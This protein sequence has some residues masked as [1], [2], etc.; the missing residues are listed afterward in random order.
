M[1]RTRHQLQQ[2][3]FPLDRMRDADRRV[4]GSLRGSPLTLAAGHGSRAPLALAHQTSATR[5]TNP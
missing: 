1:T 4:G 2:F 5:R 3:R